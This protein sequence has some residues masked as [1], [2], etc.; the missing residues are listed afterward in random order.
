PIAQGALLALDQKTSEII[1]MVGGY[2]FERSEYNRTYQALRQTGSAF[3]PI[4]YASA[5]DYGFT[6]TTEILDIPR[7]FEEE[8]PPEAGSDEVIIRKYKPSNH[9]GDFSGD[10]IFRDA[11]VRSL[12]APTIEVITK[13]SVPWALNYARRL[14]AFSPLNN[15]LTAALGSSGLTLYEMTKIYSH[16]G[17]LGK[18]ISPILIHSVEDQEG[19]SLLT[20]YKFDKRFEEKMNLAKETFMK[21]TFEDMKFG[22]MKEVFPLEDPKQLITP[23]TA[24][25]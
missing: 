1:T 10:V 13:I 23:Q 6:P 2:D 9:S 12:N 14:G 18:E 19:N 22:D 15:D 4:V 21:M 20:D 16:F 7:V 11:L 8:V 25:M 17:R 5:L 24:Y 3:K